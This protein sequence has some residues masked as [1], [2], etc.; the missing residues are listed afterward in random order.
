[1]SGGYYKVP[2]YHTAKAVWDICADG[3]ATTAQICVMLGKPRGTLRPTI[4]WLVHEGYLEA[5]DRVR[6][7]DDRGRRIYTQKVA[8][9]SDSRLFAEATADA[10]GEPFRFS[11]LMAAWPTSLATA[12]LGRVVG[13]SL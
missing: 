8:L 10:C 1:M 5:G 7:K 3:G 9:P 2:S 4:S 6:T 11:E 13:V 12:R